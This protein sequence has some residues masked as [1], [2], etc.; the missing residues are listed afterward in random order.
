MTTDFKPGRYDLEKCVLI[1]SA[2]KE[3]AIQGLLISLD[4]YEDIFSSTLSA[5]LAIEDGIDLIKNFPII[6]QEK[7]IVH[8]RTKKEFSILKFEFYSY[9]V[10]SELNIS[11]TGA[12]IYQISFVSRE[13]LVSQNKFIH[14]SIQMPNCKMVKSI[15]EQELES[16]KKYYADVCSDVFKYMPAMH[17]PFEAIM[18]SVSRAL[19]KQTQTPAYVF[20]E[21][22][23]GF[24]FKNLEQ[25]VSTAPVAEYSFSKAA[26]ADTDEKQDFFKFSEFQK[27][28]VVSNIEK[29]SSGLIGSTV[30]KFD[31]LTRTVS[32][33]T[34]SMFDDKFKQSAKL[35]ANTED[36]K[37]LTK[38]FE[39]KNPE[40]M[41][42]LVVS[43]S[44]G[45]NV[46][47]R[48]KLLT[49]YTSIKVNA[50]VPGNSNLRVGNVINCRISNQIASVNDPENQEL[51][52]KYLITALRHKITKTDYFCI[53][54]LCRDT[55]SKS[56]TK[57]L[58]TK[59]AKI[60]ND[61]TL[62]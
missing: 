54:E 36:S 47:Q 5:E 8:F 37:L 27:Q 38:D 35:G 24:H 43:N 39:F 62:K 14:R 18:M 9:Q 7:L 19:S 52:G 53:M 33:Q 28:S 26:N 21:S 16:S 13:K 29:M 15:L 31:P 45:E 17:R 20:Y 6:G 40:G 25:M 50:H 42:K 4:I 56:P 49:Q 58:K 22:S 23:D 51:S 59:N 1:N 48:Y 3:Y 32:K 10:S 60:I 46:Q 2:G 44:K 34:S 30:A 41:F 55:Y 61:E 57:D 12:K 11:E